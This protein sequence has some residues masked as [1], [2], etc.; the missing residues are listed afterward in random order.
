MSSRSFYVASFGCRASQSEG[1]AVEQQLLDGA[2]TPAGSAFA[3]DVVIV[4]TCTVTDEADREARQLIRRIAA[5]NPEASVIVTGCYAQ[6]APD[7]VAV[8]PGVSHVVGN[9]HKPILGRLALDVLDSDFVP[10]ERSGRAEVFCSDIFLEHELKPELHLGS[11][12]R[13]RAVVKVQDGCNANCSFCIIPSVRGRSRSLSPNAVVEEI[14]AL[15][16]RGYKEVVL[17]G[18]HLG[19]YG[20]DL[21]PKTSLLELVEDILACVPK[22]QRLRL[23]SIEPLEVTPE[24]VSVV[25]S[26]SRMAHHFHIPL[27][28]GSSRVLRAMRRPYQP[29]YY[30]DLLNRIR[31]EVEDA[32]IGA[33]VMVG[34]P[35]ETDAEFSETFRLVEEAPLSYLHIFPYSIR[36]GTPAADLQNQVPS[37]VAT[38]RAKALRQLIARKNASFLARMIERELDVLVLQSGEGLTSN[39][40]KVRV[41]EE[42]PV[43]E[44]VRLRVERIAGGML[45][46]TLSEVFQHHYSA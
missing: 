17:S 46:A 29:E 36:P 10:S 16:D 2:A 38:F 11:A 9:S 19:T 34:F 12:G 7:E 41:P 35:G 27:Q 21:H 33:D 23:S 45:S 22:L 8:L 39:F 3:A 14:S 31:A 32:A 5:R 28:S 40:L 37:H 20:R 26:D 13:T 30:A 4:N 6:R 43:N 24:I 25:A 42:L 15:V 1:A 18:I 44:W